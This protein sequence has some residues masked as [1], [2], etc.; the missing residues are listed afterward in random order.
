MASYIGR[1]ANLY[2]LFYAEKP[3]AQEAAFVHDCVRRYGKGTSEKLLELA[4]GTGRH[5]LEWQKLGYQ[6]VASDY[7]K[8]MLEVAQKRPRAPAP[9][10]RFEYQDMRN[11]QVQGAPFDV[12][13]CLFD[14]LGY[15]GTN[16]AI[17]ESL[18][19]IARHLRSDGLFV[20][21]FWHAGAMVRSFDPVRVRRWKTAD[22]EILRISETQL[23]VQKQ[24]GIVQYTIL[25]LKSDGTYEQL[26]ETQSN[27]YFLVQEMAALLTSSGFVPVAWHAGFTASE[28]IDTNTWHVVAVA[29]KGAE[30]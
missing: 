24:L 20:F 19:G 29:R 11:L 23:D 1:H 9:A 26:S 16:D 5:A 27:R 7:S 10:L 22:G 14:S 2:D 30:L 8:D 21:E 6:A 4:C 25:D 28:Q 13:V 12:V 3:Y 17:A 18:S 15:V